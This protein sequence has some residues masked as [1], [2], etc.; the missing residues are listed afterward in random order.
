MPDHAN[1][2]ERT[3]RS[4]E[5]SATEAVKTQTAPKAGN[6]AEGQRTPEE[7]LALMRQKYEKAGAKIDALSAT[8]KP[9]E[10]AYRSE[11][12]MDAAAAEQLFGMDQAQNS[13]SV[14]RMPMRR[15]SYRVVRSTQN[16]PSALAVD[17]HERIVQLLQLS[18]MRTHYKQGL[19][20]W[21]HT[22]IE[23]DR[24][25]NTD[26]A[27][28]MLFKQVDSMLSKGEL[29][30][31][32]AILAAMPLEG[33]SLTLM[34]GVLSITRPASQHLASREKFFNRVY[35]LC[36]AMRRDADALLGGLR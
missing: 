30:D 20:E 15:T 29:E 12:T 1:L 27:L 4:V 13:L 21:M 26:A 32:N 10:T 23:L 22:V 25:A 17:S 14:Q 36:K 2:D 5:E 28:D 24:A 31:V 7:M 35:A 3:L 33:P 18:G 6:F 34:M 16:R 19:P 11:I 8:V 9:G